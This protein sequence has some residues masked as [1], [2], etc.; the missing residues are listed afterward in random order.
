VLGLGKVPRP[1]R[2]PTGSGGTCRPFEARREGHARAPR[3]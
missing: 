3:S 1:R 2:R